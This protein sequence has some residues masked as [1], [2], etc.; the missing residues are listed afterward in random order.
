MGACSSENATPAEAASNEDPPTSTTEAGSSDDTVA[1]NDVTET[2]VA[3]DNDEPTAAPPGGGSATLTVG[4]QTW[5]FDNYYCA[6]GPEQTQNDRVSFS[7][8]AFGTHEGVRTQLDAS[9]Q[10]TDKQGRYEGEG[11]IQSVTLNDIEDFENPSVALGAESGFLGSPD[12][13]ILV[14]G[15]KVMVEASFDDNTTD[16]IE[17][18]PGTLEAT[19]GA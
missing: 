9:I 10:D 12:F 1:S 13:V 19:C 6:F 3:D 15:D 7:S 14:D 11:T 17:S 4:D 8:G 2:T 5:T 16:E 18:I